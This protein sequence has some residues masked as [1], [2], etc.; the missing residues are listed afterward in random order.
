LRALLF[1]GAT[2]V[3]ADEP[4][5]YVTETYPPYNFSD[6]NILRGIAVGLLVVASQQTTAPVQRSQIRLMPWA[7][8]YRMTLKNP[9]PCTALNHPY[10]RAGKTFQMG[11]THCR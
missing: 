6:N 2:A 10:P 4:L 8:S 5:I 11:R 7:R 3:T 1:A 9:K